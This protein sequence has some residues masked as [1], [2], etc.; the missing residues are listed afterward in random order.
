DRESGFCFAVEKLKEISKDG[1][2]RPTVVAKTTGDK[3]NKRGIVKSMDKLIGK[4]L[5]VEKAGAMSDEILEEFNLVLEKNDLSMIVIFIDTPSEIDRIF[6]KFKDLSEKF[7][8]VLSVKDYSAD[9]LVEYATR[10]AD[11]HD[12][13]IDDMAILALYAKIDQILE[14]QDGTQKKRVEEVMKQAIEKASKKSVGRAI[15]GL[16]VI[17]YDE[18]GKLLIREQDFK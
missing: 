4:V 17:K 16:F 7:D 10:Y 9:E 14:V 3:L 12:C 18:A 8:A 5:I 6:N 1:K 2:V 15:K 11:D 13:A